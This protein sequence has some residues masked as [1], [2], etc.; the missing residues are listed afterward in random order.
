LILPV[1]AELF[2]YILPLV[3]KTSSVVPIL[4]VHSP[5]EKSDY[6]PISI[7]PDVLAKAFENVM[8]ELMENN[9]SRKGL[10]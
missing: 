7:L 2:N 8:Y 6:H 10:I 3:W 5:T 4:K 9:V 1:L